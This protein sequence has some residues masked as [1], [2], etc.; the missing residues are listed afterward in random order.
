MSKTCRPVSD[1]LT[2][3]KNWRGQVS[4]FIGFFI[5]KRNRIVALVSI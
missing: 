4:F 3:W 2:Q 5:F 1:A